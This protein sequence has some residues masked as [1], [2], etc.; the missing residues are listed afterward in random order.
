[1]KPVALSILACAIALLAAP[2]KSQRDGGGSASSSTFLLPSSVL[3]GG[4]PSASKTYKL[5]ASFGSGVTANASAS[6]TFKLLGGFCATLEAK[7]ALSP[8]VTAVSPLYAPLK[9]GTKFQVNGSNLHLGA[10]TSV[11]VGTQHAVVSTRGRAFVRAT[12]PA[13][14]TPGWHDVRV[15]AGGNSST[16]PRAMGVLPMLDL[17]R[18]AIPGVPFDVSFRGSKGDAVVW[19]LSGGSASHAFTLPGFGHKF[20]LDIF[21]VMIITTMPI[22]SPDGT[23]SLPLPGVLWTRPIR[24]QGLVL[25]LNPGYAPGS[26]TNVVQL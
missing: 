18:P 9:G 12:T 22:L 16:L 5:T 26:F 23:A 2:L 21:T 14:S 11:Q 25:T 1:V 20:D 4:G 6:H 8:W 17:E 19:M 10:S 15:T 3:G 7:L 24:L 13:Q